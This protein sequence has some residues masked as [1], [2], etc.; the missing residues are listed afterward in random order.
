M[1][2]IAAFILLLAGLATSVSAEETQK[3]CFACSGKG[4]LKCEALK[5]VKGER[6]C[7]APCLKLSVGHWEK[8]DVPGHSPSEIWQKFYYGTGPK[9]GYK[10][11]P[12][13]HVGYVIV[14]TA[15]GPVDTGLCKTCNGT[16]KVKCEKCKGTAAIACTMCEGKKTVPESWT[17]T[18]N[19]KI[20]TD[21][22]YIRLTDG[23]VIKGKIV[24]TT[25]T[26]LKIKTDSG[27]YIDIAKDQVVVK[28][29]KP[30][31]SK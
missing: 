4:T 24:L 30:A 3:A 23:R 29:S 11:W 25:D 9:K 26:K 13:T 21:P 2:L 20:D 22:N 5:C 15:A 8:M 6:D 16:T 19:P 1:K 27:T 10:A 31:I 28:P 18:N 7:P 12:N 17:E 14:P